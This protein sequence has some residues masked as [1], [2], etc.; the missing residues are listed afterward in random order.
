MLR[1]RTAGLARS[2]M[3]ETIAAVSP[4]TNN[5]SGEGRGASPLP[6]LLFSLLVSIFVGSAW[7]TRALALSVVLGLLLVV[8]V[9]WPWFARRG[10]RVRVTATRDRGEVGKPLPVRI[11]T[12]NRSWLPA[13]GLVLTNSQDG[14][15]VALPSLAPLRSQPSVW[16]LTP[17]LR[18]EFPRGEVELS[19]SFPFRMWVSTGRI[20]CD[21][22]AIIWPETV[23][24]GVPKTRGA[25]VGQPIGMEEGSRIGNEGSITGPRPYQPGEAIRRVHWPQTARLGELMVCDREAFDSSPTCIALEVPPTGVSMRLLEASVSV[26]A[27]LVR[28]ADAATG[29]VH[30][31]V[32]DLQ[33][34]WTLVNGLTAALDRLAL[35]QPPQ[36]IAEGGTTGGLGLS[37]IDHP[38]TVIAES[39]AGLGQPTFRGDAIYVAEQSTAP[40]ASAA[41]RVSAENWREELPAVWRNQASPTGAVR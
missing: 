5:P 34:E 30:L 20:P 41:W 19:T 37:G 18:G 39:G 24:L 17:A 1:F 12:T 9:L 32:R 2:P 36:A 16:T 21:G 11:E 10:V 33:G 23:P 35:F 8:G 22:G 4:P 38:L 27:S 25:G 31:L 40:R 7:N 3:R 15:R 29:T 26:A 13:C 28:A 14:R 6:L